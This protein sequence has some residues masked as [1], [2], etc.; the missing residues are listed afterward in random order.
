M[1]AP[2]PNGHALRPRPRPEPCWLEVDLAAVA[3]NVRA[4]KRLV[5]PGTAVAAVVKADGYGLGAVAIAGAAIAGGAEW[6]AVARVEEG[7]QLRRAGFEVPILNLAWATPEEARAL[8]AQRITPTV[9][10]VAGARALA[11]AVPRG[12]VLPIHLKVDTG[13]SR[14]GAQ[15]AELDQLLDTLQALPN[16]RLEG[17]SSHFAAADEADLSFARLQMDRFFAASRRLAARSVRPR[18]RH[19]AN[20]A[21]T[22][23]I[24]DARLDLVR[25]GI[26]LSGHYP[27][28]DVPR[29]VTLRPAVALRA[30]LARVYDLAAGAS[31]GYGQSFVA[32][33]PMRVGLVPVGYAD[34]LPRSH[35]KGGELLLRGRRV[36]LV[37]RVSMDQCVVDVSAVHEARP[38]DEVTLIG[39]QDGGA[40]SLDEYAAWDSTIAHEALCR[41]GTRAT[42]YYGPT[43]AAED[44]LR[45]GRDSLARDVRWS[46]SP[47]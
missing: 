39:S 14:F 13:L 22:L 1:H 25:V 32:T 23:A 24:P 19:L 41:L 15:P 46:A 16:L 35:S 11:E 4:V 47:T 30:R 43:P 31:I 3:D 40:I 45:L 36:P 26:T 44:P 10:D 18:L 37:G 21:A 8:V 38:G 34:G 27:S 6:L 12:E 29:A 28:P 33:G 2:G 7:A 5:G 9:V 42:R 20:S 17:F